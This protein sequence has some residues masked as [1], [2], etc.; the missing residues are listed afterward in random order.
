M[1]TDI[2]RC[3]KSYLMKSINNE[4]VKPNTVRKY[5]R[6]LESAKIIYECNRFDLKSK[7]SFKMKTTII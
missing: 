6:Y 7:K 4:L 1:I 3:G 5:I 2:R